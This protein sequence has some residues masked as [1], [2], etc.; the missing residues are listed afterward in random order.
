MS[1]RVRVLVWHR[2]PV[3]GA[4]PVVDAYHAISQALDGTPGLLGNELLRVRG[5]AGCLVVASEWR[6]LEAFQAWEEGSA[7]RGVTAP[8]RQY[9]DG[10][11]GRAYEILEVVTEYR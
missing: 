3:D 4:Q 8:L 9:R 1:G 11:R 6:S 5:D 10:G 2:V 7:H